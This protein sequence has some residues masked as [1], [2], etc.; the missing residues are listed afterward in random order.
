MKPSKFAA[1]TLLEY[2]GD[3]SAAAVDLAEKRYGK[4]TSF[5][6]SAYSAPP[7]PEDWPQPLSAEAFN[8]LTGDIVQTIEPHT[9]ADP[10]ALL[11][12]FLT[13]FGSVAGLKA[14]FMV[15][16]TPHHTNLFAVLVGETAKS[17][18]DGEKRLG[19]P[20]EWA[21]QLAKSEMFYGTACRS[22]ATVLFEVRSACAICRTVKPSLLSLWIASTS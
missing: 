14:H 20:A 3:F 21:F 11:I 22:L 7:K 5:A 2:D 1:Y 13:T 15:E 16:A 9:E 8:G 19:R 17:R 12:Q 18:R 4:E 10:A 6:S